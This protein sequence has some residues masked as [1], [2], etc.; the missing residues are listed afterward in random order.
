[1]LCMTM[2]GWLVFELLV[3]GTLEGAFAL[4]IQKLGRVILVIIVSEL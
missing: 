1:M 3:A 2:Q 4:D